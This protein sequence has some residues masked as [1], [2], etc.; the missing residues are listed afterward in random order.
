M[1]DITAYASHSSSSLTLIH[2][3]LD[4][5]T[6]FEAF[7]VHTCEERRAAPLAGL[8]NFSQRSAAIYQGLRMITAQIVRA[9]RLRLSYAHFQQHRAQLP[10]GLRRAES[11]KWLPPI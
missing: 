9:I 5:N 8:Q 6:V 2:M 1:Q 7:G 11:S 10:E 3:G 4:D